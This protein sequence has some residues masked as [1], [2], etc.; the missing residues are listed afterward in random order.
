MQGTYDCSACTIGSLD[1]LEGPFN[2]T[3]RFDHVPCRKHHI[4]SI[5]P[6]DAGQEGNDLG[7][8]NILKGEL[9]LYRPLQF[10]LAL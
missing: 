10:R 6:L 5:Q 9:Q 4:C 2:E 3:H 7:V 8:N 1:R